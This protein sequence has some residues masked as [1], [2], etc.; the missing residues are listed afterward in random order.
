M[1][2]P[3]PPHDGFDEVRNGGEVSC[4]G[5]CRRLPRSSRLERL[6]R[7]RC[8]SPTSR[9]PVRSSRKSVI[10]LAARIGIQRVEPECGRVEEKEAVNVGMG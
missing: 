5:L 3:A 1:A 6:A 4:F 9:Q 7:S 8:S 2:K 10:F